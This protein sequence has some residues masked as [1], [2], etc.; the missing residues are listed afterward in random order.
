MINII[1]YFFVTI[2][3]WSCIA[4][5]SKGPKSYETY[6]IIKD[7]F[8]SSTELIIKFKMLL[9]LL[10]KDLMQENRIYKRIKNINRQEK[11]STINES[12]YAQLTNE[13]YTQLKKEK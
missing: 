13:L 3:F 11:I 8:F 10:I 5:L 12:N 2:F 4:I 9:N 1:A 6:I 7:I